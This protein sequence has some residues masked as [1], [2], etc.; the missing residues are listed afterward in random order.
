MLF[1]N[2]FVFAPCESPAK[3]TVRCVEL[4]ERLLTFGSD[5]LFSLGTNCSL[6]G[7]VKTR[8]LA[9]GVPLRFSATDTPSLRAQL[10][11]EKS[12]QRKK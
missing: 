2:E 5:D 3:P 6:A 4:V 7:E 8:Q 12:S 1:S 11:V 9:E 10:L